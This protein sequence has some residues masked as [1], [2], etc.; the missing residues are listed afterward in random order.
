MV[1]ITDL[2]NSLATSMM[3]KHWATL[4]SAILAIGE[5]GL[6]LPSTKS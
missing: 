4:A 6:Y 1:N 3:M 2:L 5:Q